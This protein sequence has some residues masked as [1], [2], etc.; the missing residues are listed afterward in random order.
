MINEF[1]SPSSKKSCQEFPDQDTSM[2]N[3]ATERRLVRIRVTHE[4]WKKMLAHHQPS[5]YCTYLATTS[6]S[7]M[8]IESVSSEGISSESVSSALQ[9]TFLV[10]NEARWCAIQFR[11]DAFSD[12]TALGLDSELCPDTRNRYVP[13]DHFYSRQSI[14]WLCLWPYRCSF[15]RELEQSS[16]VKAKQLR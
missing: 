10:W 9:C 3:R 16:S 8:L 5:N 6:G 11:Y 4:R 1:T 2:V 7:A 13:W 12:I 14:G 15:Y